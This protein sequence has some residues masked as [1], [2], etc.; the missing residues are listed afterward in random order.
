MAQRLP[1]L[2][3][4]LN[5]FWSKGSRFERYV[6]LSAIYRQYLAR[7][8]CAPNARP[9]CARGI[10]YICTKQNFDS[11]LHMY[12]K[13]RRRPASYL[14]SSC[15]FQIFFYFFLHAM[16]MA[17]RHAAGP[18]SIPRTWVIPRTRCAPH[19]LYRRADTMLQL[20]KK[21]ERRPASYLL[22]SCRF[23]I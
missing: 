18:G 17:H 12:H 19:A 2:S 11:Q 14:L 16:R 22:P 13:I 1:S 20:E 23:Q 10:T 9:M 4:F 8:M 15:R 5:L 7:P 6:S 3:Q 21:K